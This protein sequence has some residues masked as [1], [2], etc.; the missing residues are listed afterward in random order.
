MTSRKSQRLKFVTARV[1]DRVDAEF[2]HLQCFSC[3]DVCAVQSAFGCPDPAEAL[4]L[5][6]SLQRKVKQIAQDLGVNGTEAACAYR[7]VATLILTL[8]SPG[9]PLATGTNGDV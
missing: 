4:Q 7:D 2:G 9:R 5:Q 6:Q 8:T 1:I 3:F